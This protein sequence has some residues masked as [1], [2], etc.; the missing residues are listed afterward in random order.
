MTAFCTKC[1][2]YKEGERVRR[3]VQHSIRGV[4]FKC[5]ETVLI[6][7]TCGEELY[8]HMLNDANCDARIKAFW[9]AKGVT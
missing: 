8:H 3:V 9:L 1:R 6:C 2:A 7:R 5:P 4:S